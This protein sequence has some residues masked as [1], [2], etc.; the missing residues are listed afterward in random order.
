MKNKDAEK[1]YNSVKQKISISN[2]LEEDNKVMKKSKHSIYRS[3]AVACCAVILMTG[4]VFGK[5]IGT[6]II[7]LFGYNASD[8]VQIAVDNGYLEKVETDFIESDGI[9]FAVDSFFIDDYNLDINF[10]IKLSDKYDSRIMLGATLQDLKI[11]DENGNIVFVTHELETEMAKADGTIGTENFKPHFWGGYSMGG[12][13]VAE[14]ELM[15]HLVAY[16]SEEHKIANAKELNISFSKIYIK[17]DNNENI[18]NTNYTGNWAFKVEVPEDMYN[19]ENIIYRVKKCN[20]KNTKVSY[21]ILSNTAFKIEIPETTTNKVDY[22]VLH[23]DSP[24]SI[25]D[26]I[27]LQKEYVENSNGKRFERKYK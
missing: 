5:D 15:Y 17:K 21:A 9:A 1:I 16:G 7:N 11:V 20:D 13:E 12:E 23:S 26:K 8:G 22:K 24:K 4:V 3:V 25:F 10:K 19:R 18:I 14:D 2:F 6:F 27:A